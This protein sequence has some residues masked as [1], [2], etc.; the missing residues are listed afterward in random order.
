[1]SREG[2]REA[3]GQDADDG[4]GGVPEVPEKVEG[5]GVM[6][7]SHCETGTTY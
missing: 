4:V 2:K 7:K 5:S 6:S 1:M 3:G